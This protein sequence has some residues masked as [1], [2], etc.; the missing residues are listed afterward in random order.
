MFKNT[1]ANF[2]NDETTRIPSANLSDWR[3]LKLEL[4]A[5]GLWYSI[6]IWIMHD[7]ELELLVTDA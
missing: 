2:K 5:E 6:P 4:V 1:E 3:R 7:S